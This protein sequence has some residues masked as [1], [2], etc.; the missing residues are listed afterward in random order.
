MDPKS[1]PP[2]LSGIHDHLVTVEMPF[3]E[4][5]A[6]LEWTGVR[7]SPK[8]RARIIGKCDQ[9]ILKLQESLRTPWSEQLPEPGGN[10][11]ILSEKLAFFISSKTGLAIPST[12]TTSSQPKP[13]TR[14]YP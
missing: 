9:A 8:K 14:Q 13:T 4:T 2:Q 1:P 7:V 12:G 3:V 5:V 10:A 11:A 6:R